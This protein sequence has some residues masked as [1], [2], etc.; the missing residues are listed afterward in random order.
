MRKHRGMQSQPQTE[1]VVYVGVDVGQAQLSVATCVPGAA[2]VYA[3][4]VANEATGLAA[5]VAEVAAQWPGWRVYLVVEPTGGYEQ[6]LVRLAQQTGWAVRQVNPL[7]VRD[8]GKGE[9][10]RSKTD[11]QDALLLAAYGAA[12]Q[13]PPQAP[14]PVAVTDLDELEQRRRE[15]EALIRQESNRLAQSRWRQ[16]PP[17][18]T[19]SLERMLETLRQEL[20]AIE[21]ALRQHLAAE[22][23]LAQQRRWLLSVPGVGPKGVNYLLVLL[24]RFQALTAGEGDAKALTAFL[25]LDPK[26]HESGTTLG[27]RPTISKMG[28]V[29]GRTVLYLSALGGVR[30]DNPLRTFYRSL[31]ARGKAKKLALVAASRKLLLWAWAVFRTQTPFDPS[32]HTHL[33]T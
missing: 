6:P 33:A 3:G 21:Q 28:D 26:L 2:P 22:A 8:W 16:V 18:V 14:L 32:R 9:G 13:L 23:D 29:R 19:Q 17:A 31:V 10:W 27:P 1:P 4:T 25:G 15:L 11:R 5:W 30:G 12:K 7:Q 24:H 20:A